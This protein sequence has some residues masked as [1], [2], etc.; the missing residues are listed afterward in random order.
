MLFL[1]FVLSFL[2]LYTESLKFKKTPIPEHKVHENHPIHKFKSYNFH[3]KQCD[4][5]QKKELVKALHP[6]RKQFGKKHKEKMKHIHKTSDE[7]FYSVWLLPE[8]Y[9][10]IREK[11][12]DCLLLHGLAEEL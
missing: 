4:P 8:E 6:K 7:D 1:V 10:R 12:E 2:A 9:Q 5:K 3:L 11:F